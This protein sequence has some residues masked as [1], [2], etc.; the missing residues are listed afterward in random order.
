MV[1][2]LP[3]LQIPLK[4]NVLMSGKTSLKFGGPASILATASNTTELKALLGYIKANNLP[5]FL[6]GRGTNLIVSDVGFKGLVITL[7]GDFDKIEVSGEQM[8]CGAGAG[9]FAIARRAR[10]E[11]L[12]GLEFLSTIPGSLGGAI[13]MNAGAHGSEI[14]DS[15]EWIEVM[16]LEGEVFKYHPEDLRMGYRTSL[17]KKMPVVVMRAG[18]KL[19]KGALS[20][21]KIK[22]DGFKTHRTNSQPTKSNNCGS[23][24]ANPEG[25]A[26]GRLIDQAG[27]KGF[28]LGG[29]K[30]SEKHANFLE[31]I[32]GQKI[33]DLAKLVDHVKKRVYETSGFKLKLEAEILI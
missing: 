23:L 25:E 8:N 19:A 33:D 10:E 22:E 6:L 27:L 20:D 30:M 9:D 11:S 2:S 12:T 1:D 3:P 24:F 17:L 4:Y 18:L 28:G 14:A 7:G 31:N 26:A 32:D 13:R 21:I 29:F 15:C 16:D 5:W